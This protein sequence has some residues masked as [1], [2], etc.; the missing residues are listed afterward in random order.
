MSGFHIHYNF[1]PFFP[2]IKQNVWG[3]PPRPQWQFGHGSHWDL[4]VAVVWDG[5]ATKPIEMMG[6]FHELRSPTTPRSRHA[7]DLCVDSRLFPSA[8]RVWKSRR[9]QQTQHFF[10]FFTIHSTR[11]AG[12]EFAGRFWTLDSRRLTGLDS[13]HE[14][15]VLK[16]HRNVWNAFSVVC[17]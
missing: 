9:E 1:I 10:I 17:G 6:F 7:P 14:Y 2:M 11:N 8:E 12:T 13:L 15:Q 16:M 5:L 3:F 4:T